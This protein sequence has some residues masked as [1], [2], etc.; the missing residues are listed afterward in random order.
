MTINLSRWELYFIAIVFGL[1]A[2]NYVWMERDYLRLKAAMEAR[3]PCEQIP[4][5]EGGPVKRFRYDPERG[6]LINIETG[7]AW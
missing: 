5:G 7:E 1:L 2:I 3:V 4:T 6:Q